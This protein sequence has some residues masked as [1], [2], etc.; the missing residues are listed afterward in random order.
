MPGTSASRFRGRS[1]RAAVRPAAAVIVDDD[2]DHAVIIRHM[3]AEVAPW[4]PVVAVTDPRDLV[5]RLAGEAPD[6]ALLLIDRMLAGRESLW[7]VSRLAALRPDLTL[8][9]LSSALSDDERRRAIDAGAHHAAQ[10][11]GSLDGW[12]SLLGSLLDA[13]GAARGA[14]A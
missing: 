14:V 13:G 1:E 10:K 7:L 11:P 4:L 2:I 3:L 6:D 5:A 8:A 12:R 9:V